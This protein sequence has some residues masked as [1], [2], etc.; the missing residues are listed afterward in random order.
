MLTGSVTFGSAISISV[1]WTT[2]KNISLSKFLSLQFVDTGD[3]YI[4]FSVDD[5]I[6]YVATFQ[7]GTPDSQD[8]ETTYKILAN[9]SLAPKADGG[10]QRVSVEKTSLSMVMYTTHN[11]CDPTTWFYASERIVGE[12][13][14]DSGDHQTFTLQNP[15]MIDAT[16][17]KVTN[18]DDGLVDAQGHSYRL[19]ATV[20]GVPVVEQDPHKGAGGDFTVDYVAGS[21]TFLAPLKQGDVVAVSYNASRSSLFTLKPDPKSKL[22]ISFSRT[23]FSTDVQL[24][25]SVIFSIWGIADFFLPPQ[26]IGVGKDQI[27]SGTKIPLKTFTYK[28]IAD[29]YATATG[30]VPAARAMGG[31]GW[32]GMAQDLMMLEHDYVAS[33]V[34]HSY[35]GMEARVQL[36][37]EV[38]VGG[39]VSKTT[40]F[41]ISDVDS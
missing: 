11:F 6:C 28:S 21:L 27:P 9:K 15:N 18:E 22:T 32:R 10:V 5:G 35:S 38:A 1:D 12:V 26:A 8:F 24:N 19:S 16:H 14:A 31:P 37:H 30:L 41:C 23:S 17:G 20:N 7:K 3:S 29:F 25:D 36:Q 40:F 39:T 33:I 4:G 13:A 2:L 34:L